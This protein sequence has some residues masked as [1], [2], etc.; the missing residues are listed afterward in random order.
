M[1]YNKMRST[2]LFSGLLLLSSTVEANNTELA[3]QVDALWQANN[4]AAAEALLAPLLTKK[5]K[6]AQLLALLG[7]THAGLKNNDRA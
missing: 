1:L 3:S 6:D 2:F 5:S 4:Y 7:R